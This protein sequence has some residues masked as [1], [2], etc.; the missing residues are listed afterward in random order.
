MR[1]AKRKQGKTSTRR[2]ES[3]ESKHEIR[4]GQEEQARG[5][6]EVGEAGTEQIGDGRGGHEARQ[7]REKRSHDKVYAKEA[8][9]LL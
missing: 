1:V 4:R 9:P 5:E 3:R 8:I 2:G 6:A 7:K